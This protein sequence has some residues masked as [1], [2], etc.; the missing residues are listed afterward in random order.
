MFF[1]EHHEPVEREGLHE[2]LTMGKSDS[3]LIPSD[4]FEKD[5]PFLLSSAQKVEKRDK[6][7]GK[8]LP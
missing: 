2:E 7:A 5:N 1:I 6:T 3:P 8:F 4:V